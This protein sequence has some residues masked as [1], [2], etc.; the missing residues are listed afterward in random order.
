MLCVSAFFSSCETALF[1]LSRAYRSKLSSERS[2]SSQLIAELLKE[3]RRLIIT[4]LI[5]NDLVNI[6]IGVTGASIVLRLMG[7]NSDLIAIVGATLILLVLGEILPKSLA[8]RNAPRYVHHVALPLEFV[9]RLVFPIRWGV[10][11]IVDAVLHLLGG[12]TAAGEEAISEDEFRALIAAGEEAGVFHEAEIAMIK[13]VFA[14]SDTVVSQV[15]TPR[16]DIETIDVANDLDQT[17]DL[18]KESH[19]SRIPV[20]E[21]DA[22]TIVGILYAKD[23]LRWRRG[24]SPASSLRELMRQPFFVP[25]GK[26]INELLQEFQ[27]QKVHQAIVLD[28]YGG[29]A[30]L[31]TM[32]DLLEEL[33]GEINDEFDLPAAS[34]TPFQP[35]SET[36]YRVAAMLPVAEA[37][38][39]LACELPAGDYETVGGLVLHLFGR[40]P[41]RGESVASNG[42]TFTVEKIHG[43]RILE[44]VVERSESS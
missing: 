5:G 44:V 2:A 19:F 41:R 14:F 3:P 12:R 24:T 28:E 22:D 9:A 38:E 7:G 20:Y 16:T 17:V 42:L 8:L 30:G 27:Q 33:V 15:M 35:L 39:A 10:H 37:S 23:L 11:K 18:I 26:R 21:G 43:T 32:E 13:K 4:L 25:E 6:A 1:S 36:R 34:A 29:V 31:V 40:L